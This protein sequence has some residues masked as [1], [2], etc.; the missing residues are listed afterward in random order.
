[1]C[2]IGARHQRHVFLFDKCML[3]TK[4]RDGDSVT[5]KAVIGVSRLYTWFIRLASLRSQCLN[6]QVHACLQLARAFL[7]ENHSKDLL[8][9]EMALFED[10]KNRFMFK[11]SVNNQFFVINI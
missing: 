9:F 1:L 2:V 11:V 6:Y 3:V 4:L 5:I 8:R 7:V 10:H